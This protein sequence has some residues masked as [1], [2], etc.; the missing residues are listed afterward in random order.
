MS[1]MTFLWT[2]NDV[3]V[4]KERR[5]GACEN[6]ASENISMLLSEITLF[7]YEHILA[8]KAICVNAGLHTSYKLHLDISRNIRV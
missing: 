7:V 3:I 8:W 5:S 6:P 2:T 1:L 4:E